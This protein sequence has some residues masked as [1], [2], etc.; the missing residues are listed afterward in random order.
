MTK[1]KFLTARWNNW[2]TLAFGL[3]ALIFGIIAL[4]TFTAIGWPS[5]AGIVVLGAFY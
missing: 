5:F 3:P 4:T 2:L 1:D